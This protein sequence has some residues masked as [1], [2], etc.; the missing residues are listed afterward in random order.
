MAQSS[1]P[2]GH[3]LKVRAASLTFSHFSLPQA[4]QSLQSWE[5]QHNFVTL[6]P[7]SL[8]CEPVSPLEGPCFCRSHSQLKLAPIPTALLEVIGVFWEFLVV[9][10]CPII[11]TP[12]KIP[13]LE[14]IQAQKTGW[15]TIKSS[16]FHVSLILSEGLTHDLLVFVTSNQTLVQ[17][18]FHQ[19][20]SLNQ[21]HLQISG[22]FILLVEKS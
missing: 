18:E 5:L 8:S 20:F 14:N 17:G 21:K 3:P 9:A 19:A 13:S 11:T 15:L 2:W 10:F 7:C 16:Y 12:H 4:G 22:F 6:F 1:H